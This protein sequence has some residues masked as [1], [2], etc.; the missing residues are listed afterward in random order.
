[1]GDLREYDE[2]HKDIDIESHLSGVSGPFRKNILEQ[3][4]SPFKPLI[5][6]SERSLVSGIDSSVMSN[7]N[8][9]YAI[10]CLLM[11]HW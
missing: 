3:L 5:S 11:D 1:M 8:I 4:R 7:V 9:F 10:R 6:P 2:A